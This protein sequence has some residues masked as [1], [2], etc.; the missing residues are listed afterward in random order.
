MVTCFT[1]SCHKTRIQV[2]LESVFFYC[3]LITFSWQ[4]IVISFSHIS[5]SY[6]R[7]IGTKPQKALSD[8]T[9]SV[10]EGETIGLIGANGAG[11]STSIRLLMDFIRPTEGELR[12]FDVPPGSPQLRRKIGY[13]PEVANFPPNLC[14]LDLLRFTG[15]TCEI[16]SKVLQSRSE[17]FLTLLDL[18]EVRKHP[19]RSYSKGMQ[20]RA[21]FTIALINDP[22]LL[23]L[24]EPMSG[25][26]PMGRKKILDLIGQLKMQGKTILFCSHILEDVDRLVDSILIL[27]KGKKL[28]QGPPLELAKQENQATMAEG[29][30]NM[31]KREDA[32]A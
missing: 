8:L 20:Q 9:F 16:P 30:V 28:F 11:K 14:I 17:E 1:F 31:V 5:K 13:L 32:H 15:T 7:E 10:Q 6:T 26:D 24:D 29:F 22:E 27:H 25:L 19:L 3:L 4:N 21:N 23:I 12:L 2:T 18:W